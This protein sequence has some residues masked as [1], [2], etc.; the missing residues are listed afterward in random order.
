MATRIVVFVTKSIL[1]QMRQTT[2]KVCSK[3]IS[4]NIFLEIHTPDLILFTCL[5]KGIIEQHTSC[6]LHCTHRDYRVHK[7]SEERGHSVPTHLDS[8]ASFRKY[9]DIMLTKQSIKQFGFCHSVIRGTETLVISANV[10]KF[11][12]LL[13]S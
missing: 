6:T 12:I 13:W 8:F 9:C 7:P 11:T 1:M 5:Y 4:L 10:T 3:N 2:I